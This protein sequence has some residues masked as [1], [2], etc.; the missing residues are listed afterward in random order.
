MQFVE[1]NELDK[2]LELYEK[3]GG[4]EKAASQ[5]EE[6]I[7][8]YVRDQNEILCGSLTKIVEERA[9]QNYAKLDLHIK[10]YVE[11]LGVK[12][13]EATKS[14][15][16]SSLDRMRRDLITEVML[17]IKNKGE[18]IR[19]SIVNTQKSYEATLEKS[20]ETRN[21]DFQSKI[22]EEVT[23]FDKR[24]M[25]KTI[26]I[27]ERSILTVTT[28]ISRETQESLSQHLSLIG[29]IVEEL[30]AD[31]SIE[32]SKKLVDKSAIEQKMREIEYELT[33]KAQAVIDFN[34]NQAR[35]NMEQAARA[36]VQEGI[37]QAASQIISGLT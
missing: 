8:K 35:S 22:R 32:M 15:L 23:E 26:N 11:N 30:R 3:I 18:E 37:K 7:R 34:V 25:E 13:E 10:K 12:I 29:K 4:G 2:R 17:T 1:V 28:T 36:E 14:M 21:Q 24:V 19:T 33:K 16:A 6:K 9:A 27:A 20:F 31:L 5:V